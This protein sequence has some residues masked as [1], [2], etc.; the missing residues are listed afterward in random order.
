MRVA[1]FMIIS[2]I[3]AII[4]GAVSATACSTST[5]D[6]AK[7]TDTIPSYIDSISTL[8]LD[9]VYSITTYVISS[10]NFATVT[11]VDGTECYCDQHVANDLRL[12]LN[13]DANDS[14]E[15]W[16]NNDSEHEIVYKR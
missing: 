7:N 5:N 3:I 15:I 6:V 14:F 9:E 1:R 8:S 4:I 16:T 13:H 11:L 2:G 12:S 10:D